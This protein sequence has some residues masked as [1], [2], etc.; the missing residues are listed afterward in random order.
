MKCPHCKSQHVYI[1][2]FSIECGENINCINWTQKQ[3]NVVKQMLQSQ[4]TY[5]KYEEEYE[6]NRHL[7][8]EDDDFDSPYYTYLATHNLD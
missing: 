2:A 4:N 6:N 3:S 1:G 8:S 7:L 5:K